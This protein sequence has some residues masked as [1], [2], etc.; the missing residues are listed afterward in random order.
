ME[1][2]ERRSYLEIGA[3][4]DNKKKGPDHY[5]AKV[6][7]LYLVRLCLFFL[8]R[9]LLFMRKCYTYL[10]KYFLFFS[11]PF[12]TIPA[13]RWLQWYIRAA[14]I[15][16]DNRRPQKLQLN[17]PHLFWSIQNPCIPRG[18][19]TMRV[20]GWSDIYLLLFSLNVRTVNQ[21]PI[22]SQSSNICAQ[23]TTLYLER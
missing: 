12:F 22:F 21:I 16:S 20:F 17:S 13:S 14:C 18:L 6:E 8:S 3:E 23:K 9:K 19:P 10:T 4:N 7:R 11:P 2:N 1:I 15:L 5:Y